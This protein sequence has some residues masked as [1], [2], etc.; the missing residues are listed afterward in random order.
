M[1]LTTD[2]IGACL[3]FRALGS[4]FIIYNLNECPN[5]TM[6]RVKLTTDIIGAC[7][8]FR[9]LGSSFIIYN[10]NECPNDTMSE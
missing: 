9:A 8:T 4:S 7:L 10:L 6:S 2:I 5:D 1:K 3:T